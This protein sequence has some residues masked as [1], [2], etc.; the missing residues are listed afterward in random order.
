MCA[1]V[2]T[3]VIVRLSHWSEAMVGG[4]KAQS[5]LIDLEILGC[6]ES[7]FCSPCFINKKRII[8]LPE[9]RC[10]FS[11]EKQNMIL[12]MLCCCN[13]KARKAENTKART[14]AELYL[15]TCYGQVPAKVAIDDFCMRHN[16][17]WNGE[18]ERGSPLTLGHFNELM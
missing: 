6:C 12:K 8:Y 14:A 11:L 2:T 5:P 13:G 7:S 1:P 15:I 9:N 18:K 17:H 4:G 10:M 3:R 16:I